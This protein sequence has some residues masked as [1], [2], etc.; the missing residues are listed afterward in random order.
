MSTTEHGSVADQTLLDL[1]GF[2]TISA[3]NLLEESR[4]YGPIRLLE[5]ADRVIEAFASLGMTSDWYGALQTRIKT[6]GR[7]LTDG[8]EV[9][10]VLLDDLVAEVVGRRLANAGALSSV[11]KSA[12]T[13][14]EES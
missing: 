10:Q 9:F 7:A 1:V 14:E 3:R 8:V 5:L 12:A 2:A 6:G 11:E 4:D 13:V